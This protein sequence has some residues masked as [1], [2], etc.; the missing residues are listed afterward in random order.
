MNLKTVSPSSSNSYSEPRLQKPAY[1]VLKDG[2][3]AVV[4][5]KVTVE[6]ASQSPT[7]AKRVT[8][9]A[10]EKETEG[11]R[12]DPEAIAEYYQQRP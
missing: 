2:A 9:V 8:V 5:P 4:A 12:Y 1:P 3:T 7:P 6:Q 11:L 10:S